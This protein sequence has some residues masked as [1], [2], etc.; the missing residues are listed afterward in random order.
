MASWVNFDTRIGWHQRGYRVK[1]NAEPM[2]EDKQGNKIFHEA[3]VE[4]KRSS[5]MTSPREILKDY[6]QYRVSIQEQ[7]GFN[8][9]VRNIKAKDEADLFNL[10]KCWYKDDLTKLALLEIHKQN[11][12][13][14]VTVIYGDTSTPWPKVAIEHQNAVITA[15]PRQE[16]T[17]PA[18]SPSTG[19]TKAIVSDLMALRAENQSRVRDA[20]TESASALPPPP[21]SLATNPP[22]TPKSKEHDE[23]ELGRPTF[24]H[25]REVA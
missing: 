22:A 2:G 19:R 11:K 25:K 7:E 14:T 16:G 6:P 21:S 23:D 9:V 4:E 5:T 10:L 12:D 15:K 24:C 3:D 20:M 17:V 8:I 1:F 13:G 18:S